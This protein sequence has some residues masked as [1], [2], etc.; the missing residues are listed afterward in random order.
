MK[1]KLQSLFFVCP[2]WL[3]VVAA[4]ALFVSCGQK[5]NSLVHERYELLSKLSLQ[6]EQKNLTEQQQE[7]QLLMLARAEEMG[8]SVLQ[9]ESHQRIATTCMVRGELDKAIDEMNKAMRLAPADSLDFISQTSL[10]LCQIFLQQDAADSAR[11]Y[12]NH[13]IEVSPSV[14]ETDLYRMSHVYVLANETIQDGELAEL[15]GKYLEP[16]DVYT[17][18]ELLRLRKAIRERN[19]EKQA[20]LDDCTLLLVL[21]DSISK[22]E[23]SE[24]MARIHQLLHDR[25]VEQTR[26]D[27]ATQRIRYYIIVIVVLLLLLAVSVVGWC[28]RQRA[29]IAHANELEALSLAESV[30]REAEQVHKENLQ[31][32]KLYYEHL[33][34]IILPI[35]N[36]HRGKSGHINLEE[37]QWELI[38]RNTDSVIPN[39][40]EKIRRNHP[41]LTVDDVRFCCLIMMRVPNVIMA[42]VYGIATSSVAVR[43]QRMKRKLD[44]D[45]HEQTLEN[46]LNKYLI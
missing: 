16:S 27:M 17:Q 18:A 5:E 45:I 7:C 19:G 44:S 6:Y 15:I 25:E 9:A 12:L 13:A 46:Y 1:G 40:T 42:D 22:L 3:S 39:F 33:Y 20:A 38:E 8:D 28:Y 37:A 35:L 11:F 24:S 29:R 14:V 2:V 31:L 36:A 32:Q 4:I 34:A 43:K 21:T 30:Q 10:M 26:A 23:S 41:T